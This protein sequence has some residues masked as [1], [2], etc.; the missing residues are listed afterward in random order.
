ML[1]RRGDAWEPEGTTAA[2]V[3]LL[4]LSVF[5]SCLPS[6]CG[7][8]GEGGLAGEVEALETRDGAGF[9]VLSFFFLIILFLATLCTMRNL[10]FLFFFLSF[11]MWHS[12]QGLSSLTRD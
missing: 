1:G 4:S 8:E 2:G 11:T 10:R 7:L 12:L 6:G 5:P 3:S 9:D